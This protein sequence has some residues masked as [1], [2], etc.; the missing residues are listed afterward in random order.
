MFYSCHALQYAYN[1][2]IQYNMDHESS[3]DLQIVSHYQRT[4]VGDKAPG[5]LKFSSNSSDTAL[6]R[7]LAARMSAKVAPPKDTQRGE[8]SPYVRVVGFH[9]R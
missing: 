2:W 9:P 3:R 6:D 7:G 4:R 5:A 1:V 8:L